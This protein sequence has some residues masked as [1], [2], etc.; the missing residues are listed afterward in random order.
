MGAAYWPG[1]H[2]DT[3]YD[4]ATGAARVEEAHLEARRAERPPFQPTLKRGSVLIRDMRMW[5]AGT[6]N[7]TEEPRPMI[8]M[9]H[10]V[11]WWSTAGEV[12]FP[13]S[14]EGFFAGAPFRTA[15]RFVE[16]EVDYLKHGEAYDVK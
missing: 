10:W 15:T 3:R 4:I 7:H 14:A 11:P 16:G 6:V 1:T 13:K 5:H 2:L 8:A 9:I 12:P